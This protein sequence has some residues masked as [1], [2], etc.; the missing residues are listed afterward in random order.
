M[1]WM[2]LGS[3]T[4]WVLWRSSLA[5]VIKNTAVE[6]PI[7]VDKFDLFSFYRIIFQQKKKNHT[8]R[9]MIKKEKRKLCDTISA[10]W[11]FVYFFCIIIIFFSV[12]FITCYKSPLGSCT[13]SYTWYIHLFSN[14]IANSSIIVVIA[15]IILNIFLLF[16]YRQ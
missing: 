13:V 5:S 1:Y 16:I 12:R 11:L 3:S 9:V 2:E 6:T 10:N 14:F 4:K 8:F 7:L 15:I